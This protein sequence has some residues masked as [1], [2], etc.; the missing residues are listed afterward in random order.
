MRLQPLSAAATRLPKSAT[1]QSARPS[2]ANTAPIP[3]RAD[4]RFTHT[5]EIPNDRAGT[6]S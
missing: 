3:G 5:V 4:L 2:A 1:S 6:T